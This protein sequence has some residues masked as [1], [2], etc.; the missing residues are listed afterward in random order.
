METPFIILAPTSLKKKATGDGKAS[1]VEMVVAASRICR[2]IGDSD[3][4]DALH[5]AV[6]GWNEYDDLVETMY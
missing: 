3:Q 1:K 6:V 5:C 2:E 4:A